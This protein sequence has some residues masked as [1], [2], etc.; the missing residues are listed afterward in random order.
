MKLYHI[1]AVDKKNGIGKDGTLPWPKLKEDLKF[2]KETTLGGTLIMGRKTFDSIGKKPLPGRDNFV[3][4]RTA[5]PDGSDGM[6]L[7]F[8]NS[9]GSALE[10]V[11]T[12][13]VFIIGGSEIF[14]Q[15]LE[16]IDG[17]YMTHIDK[18]YP[19]DTFY[20]E[21]P[22]SFEKKGSWALKNGPGEPK[23]EVSEYVRSKER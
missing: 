9:L 8:F 2:F 19:A 17:I 12:E 15:T 22:S 6:K 3:L 16:L 5:T 14:R 1:V 13:R 7:R 4:S 20:P 11:R 10:S 23:L 18:T 21:L